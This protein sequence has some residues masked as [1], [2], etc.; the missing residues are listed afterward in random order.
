MNI[1]ILFFLVLKVISGK[2]I[3]L[4]LKAKTTSS[5]VTVTTRA[6]SDVH[7]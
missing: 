7:L 2:K 4:D 3:H 1:L 5:K 6:E